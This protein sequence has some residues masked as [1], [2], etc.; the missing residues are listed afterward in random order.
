MRIIYVGGPTAVLEIDGVRLLTDPTFDPSGQ[1]YELPA[2]TLRKTRGPSIQP[3]DDGRIDAVLL[4]HDSHFDNLDRGEREF[5]SRVPRVLTTAAGA[6]QLGS[7][8]VGLT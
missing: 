4:S 1:S 3:A 8:S 5:L 7:P 6:G 2:Y